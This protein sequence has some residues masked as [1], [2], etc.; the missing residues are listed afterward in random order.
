M[1][2]RRVGAEHAKRWRTDGY[3]EVNIRLSQ[4]FENY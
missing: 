1:K 4:F 3:D 2:I